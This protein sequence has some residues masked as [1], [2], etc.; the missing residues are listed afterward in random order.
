MLI[1]KS[2]HYF[3]HLSISIIDKFYYLLHLHMDAGMCRCSNGRL[4]SATDGARWGSLPPVSA[5]PSIGRRWYR[6]T[7]TSQKQLHTR[8]KLQKESFFR[9]EF[10]MMPIKKGG[11]PAAQNKHYPIYLF[12]VKQSLENEMVNPRRYFYNHQQEIFSKQI[13]HNTGQYIPAKGRQEVVNKATR[14][15]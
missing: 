9:A 1:V 3:K 7:G 6:S 4:H 14:L 10:P 13:N 12:H 2:Y 5:Q 15:H 11:R 8:T